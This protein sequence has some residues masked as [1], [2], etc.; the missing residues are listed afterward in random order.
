MISFL[1]III[2]FIFNLVY[3]A[4]CI[5]QYPPIW[6]TSNY[7]RSGNQNLFTTLTGSGNIY[8]YNFPFSSNLSGI[9][10]LGYGIKAY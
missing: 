4:D 8:T 7:I 1:N 9:P 6:L 2:L 3:Q 10:H 5:V